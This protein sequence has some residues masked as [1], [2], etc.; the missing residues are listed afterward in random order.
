M[1]QRLPDSLY[2]DELMKNMDIRVANMALYYRNE[3]KLIQDIQKFGPDIIMVAFCYSLNGDVDLMLRRCGLSATMFLTHDLRSIKR[4]PKANLDPLQK[5][6]LNELGNNEYFSK[7]N[8]KLIG[9]HF[10]GE[11]RG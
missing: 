5:M 9:F 10:S 7:S 6:F 1:S 11:T 3:K 8:S 2:N 4:N